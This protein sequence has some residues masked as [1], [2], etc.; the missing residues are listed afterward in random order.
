[1]PPLERYARFL[2][3]RAPVVVLVVL[4]VTA[5]MFAGIRR[6]RAEF[7]IDASLPQGHPFVE[8]DRQIR[9]EF[10]GRNTMIVAVVPR[11]GDV[12][13]PEV[14]EV[15]QR[16]T[17]DALELEDVMA[18]NV[19]SLAAP[20]VRYPEERG[21][22]ISVGYLMKE[23]PR[24]P[25][26]IAALRARLQSDPQ[27][28]GMLV[29]RD[30]RAA[31]VLL[32][33]WPNASAEDVF[34]RT[35]RLVE[36]YRDRPLDFYFAGEQVLA[37]SDK[38]QSRAV[39]VRTPFTFLV[40]ALM[41]LLSFR[42]L[43]GMFVPMLTATL[44]TVWGLGLMGFTGVVI[45]GWNVA[46]PILLIAVAAAHS[47]Q[48]LKRYG[49]EVAR[50]HDNRDAVIRSTVAMG[51]V[52]VA[53]GLTAA[54]GFASLALFGVRSIGNFGLSCSYGI[55][56]AVLLEMT[57]I[58]A[59]RALLPAPR[60]V[61]GEGGPTHAFLSFLA[62]SILGRRGRGVVVAAALVLALAVAGALRIRTYG[63]ARDYMP[64]GGVARTHLEAIEQHF[65]G[66]V[67]MTVLSDDPRR[68]RAHDLREDP[69]HAG[70]AGGDLRR[71]LARPGLAARRPLRRDADRGGR[72][73]PL[74]L[75]RL[76]RH[77]ARHG[78][79]LGDRDGDGDRGRLRDLLPLSPARGA[80]APRQRRGGVPRGA[81]HLGPCGP[82][83]R[84]EHR[85][86]LR[87][88]GVLPLPR[89]LALRHA[90][91]ARHGRL[92]RGGAVDHAGDGAAHAA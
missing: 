57:F 14:L 26:E 55:A 33:F 75:H 48:M 64:R 77:P 3:R 76:D 53:A 83:R 79:R 38:E 39:A 16:L 52:M 35:T 67:T 45:D 8:I 73:L 32:D 51:P 90:H 30:Q 87:R 82:V 61:P 58:P 68:E 10:G 13:R 65:P 50:S 46:V 9:T 43:Q 54:L 60:R 47:A 92:V 42:S 91:A 20:S 5:G 18:Q 24:T 41:L 15:V 2:I 12:W 70:R 23:V 4:L 63:S 37:M 34:G 6:L 22:T 40:I 66:T 80:G 69:E 56:S 25:E 59:L 71:L 44:S 88:D 86:G 1:M 11:E 74:R 29:T 49:E 78:L 17:F 84:G 19:V 7:S 36:P 85:R 81:A 31:L 21:G 27:L 89:P 28:D 62:R 72:R